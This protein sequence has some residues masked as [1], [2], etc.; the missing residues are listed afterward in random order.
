MNNAN[1]LLLILISP[2]L[3][4]NSKQ[5]IIY[6]THWF[7]VHALTGELARSKRHYEGQTQK[8]KKYYTRIVEQMQQFSVE[9]VQQM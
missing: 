8:L 4:A 7:S 3:S 1:M 6:K 5:D 9:I 2:S